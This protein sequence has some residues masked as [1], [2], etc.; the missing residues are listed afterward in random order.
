VTIL[1]YCFVSALCLVV[2]FLVD[3]A[4]SSGPWPTKR[5]KRTENLIGNNN[6]RKSSSSSKDPNLPGRFISAASSRSVSPT[7]SIKS[8]VGS[9][10]SSSSSSSTMSLGSCHPL[11]RR[12]AS[13]RADLL[14]AHQRPDYSKW[15][16]RGRPV[17]EEE[18]ERDVSEDES[19]KAFRRR[20][21]RIVKM[22]NPPT[23]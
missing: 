15:G 23:V 20:L 19:D 3:N 5:T 4:S 22:S 1:S 6:H 11:G 2:F 17:E 13:P 12:G 8:G 18:D 21:K 14:Y 7:P 9:E 10:T 16:R